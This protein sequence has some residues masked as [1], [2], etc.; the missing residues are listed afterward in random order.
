M[1]LKKISVGVICFSLLSLLGYADTID[2]NMP[3]NE[4]IWTQP[5][6]LGDGKGFRKQMADNGIDFKLW[7]SSIYQGLDA[8]VSNKE[9][10]S[11]KVDVFINL[12]SEKLGLW[13][14]GGFSAHLEYGHGKAPSFLGGTVFPVNVMQITPLGSQNK[15]VA[16]SLSF[17]QKIND[18]FTLMLG[19]INV[20]DL[21]ANNPFFGGNGTQRFMNLAFVAPPSGVVYPVIMGGI[22][23]V[24]TK[25]IAWRVMVFDANDRTNN[26]NFENLFKDGINTSVTGSYATSIEGRKSSLSVTATYSTKNGPDLSVLPPNLATTTKDGSYNV[27][28]QLTHNI[29]ESEEGAWGAYLRAAVADGN[30]NTIQNSLVG[31]IGGQAIFFERPKD[32][33]G[34]GY[35]YYN[36][37]DYLKNTGDPSID[38]K[39]EYGTEI[40]YNVEVT[41]WLHITGD[42]QYV[43][44]ADT[45]YDADVIL[46]IRSNIKF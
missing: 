16:T 22:L 17:T 31:G 14:G 27:G 29:Q 11:G 40:F 3:E 43:N 23:R 39:K 4:S 6:L 8:A 36:F 37:S 9:K 19:K 41:P 20:I 18:T 1:H 13:E 7:H 34:I 10:Y 24:Q 15:V 45:Q 38:M 12:N 42:I 46:G 25:P 30:P 32:T 28:F 44:P 21:F 26:Y 35:Y 2:N 33:F 5:Y